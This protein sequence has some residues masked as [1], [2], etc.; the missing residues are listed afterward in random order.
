M[1]MRKRVFAGALG[2][3][4]SGTA[5]FA[6]QNDLDPVTVTASLNP[7]RASQTGRN[8]IIIKGEK[9][10]ALPVHSID[11][12]LR[13]VPG[14]EVQARGPLGSQSDIVLRGGT[15]QQVLVI[16]DGV[17]VNDPN[18]GHFSST[19]PIAPGEIDRIEI[20]KGA[21]SALYGSEAVGGV[22]N[23][24]TKTFA[25]K[26]SIQK[27]Q[28]A[29][30]FTAGEYELLGVNA[31]VYTSNGKTSFGAGVLS[32]N[33]SGQPQ[34]GI[35]GFVYANT[36]SA[37]IGHQFNDKWNLAFRTAYDHRNFA[38]QNFYTNFV[39]DTAQET[40]RT[41][42]N[43]LQLSRNSANNTLRIQAG[44]K[45]LNDS[46]AFNA[47]TATNQSKS[48]LWQALVTDEIRL[49]TKTA[50]T[51]GVQ[52]I[53][54]KIV[55]NDRGDHVVNQ[56]AAFLVLNQQVGEKFFFAPAARLEWNERAGWEFVPQVNLSYRVHNLQ[57]RGSA[58]KTIRDADFTE[59]Y[60]NYNKAFVSS[61]RIGNPDL[62]AERS[63]SYEA[64][65]DYFI[66]NSL[67]LS[68][69]FFQRYHK[70]LIDYVNTPY[71][72]MPRKV[73]LS[74]T[75]TYALAENIAEVTTTGVETDLQYS[76][77]LSTNSSL[78]ANL[79]F[80]WLNSETDNGVPSL[81]LSTHAKYLTNFTVQYSHRAFSFSVNG[82]YKQRPAQPSANPAIAKVS[83]DY[84]VF[85]AK[86][87][88]FLLKKILSVFVEV[89][90]IGNRTYTDLL[91]AP[92]PR[93]WFMG[94]IKISLK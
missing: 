11:E 74:P 24:I 46:F 43:Q 77:T 38:A 89:D 5:T 93:R 47:H 82:L 64:G 92:M 54:K 62:K 32:N 94:G 87:E 90:N 78:W 72:E 65:A 76:K 4:L 50:L 40:V 26:Q 25:T 6:Q 8:L 18:T 34:R 36:V 84:I 33:T 10:A 81:Y 61:G 16:V 58:G 63:F 69:T 57:L 9:F 49:S 37:S 21:S 48:E 53:S 14:V 29:A 71:S 13:Y 83:T 1:A 52:Y 31:G 23:I 45:N 80:T 17:R 30:Q 3:A 88:A 55:S 20:L 56:A 41:F 68:G 60:N 51:P 44:Y 86:G 39:S 66:S 70:N 35:H 85:N 75:G 73:N 7:I 22:I 12:L 91:G 19:I 67:K 27:L 15:F 79:G 28:T 59:R 42:W 2:L